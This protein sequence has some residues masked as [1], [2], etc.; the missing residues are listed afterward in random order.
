ML[1]VCMSIAGSVPVI[2]CLVLWLIQKENYHFFLGR[3]LLL[4]SMF[5]YLVPFQLIKYVLPEWTVPLLKLPME[6][7]IQQDFYKVVELQSFISQDDSLWIPKWVSVIVNIWLCCIGTFAVYQILKYRIDI[8][9]MLSQ[10][11]KKSVDIN[12]R[13][14]EILVNKNIHTPYTV[15]FIKQTIILPEVSL[16]HPCF[17]MCYRHEDQHRRNHDSFMKLIGVVIICIHWFNPIAILLLW[18]YS[19]TAEYICDAKATEECSK[20]E[21]KQY[22]RLLAELA[23]EEEELSVVWKN[24]LSGSERL[25]RRRICYLMKR[26]SLMKKGIAI[27]T[28][29]ITVY[30]SASTILAYEPFMSADDK[31]MEVSTFSDF[32]EVLEENSY[33]IYDF[34]VSDTVVVYEDGT[35]F[36]IIMEKELEY[37]LCNH[38]MKNCYYQVHRSNSTGGCTVHV[39]NAQRCTK[40]GYIKTGSLHSTHTYTVCPHK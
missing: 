27:I 11:V 28:A 35:R 19:V 21:K 39:Y 8:R 4:T 25:M 23:T 30:A 36:P 37:A 14:T 13:K 24:S 34:S 7:H 16:N 38:V 3:I 18:L 20:E 29:A 6:I 5:F 2:V 26:K 9:R 40:C 32:G 1:C 17:E 33:D 12:G 22:A 10:S 15:G 31:T